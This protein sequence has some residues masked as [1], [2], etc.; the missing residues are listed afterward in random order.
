MA[1][2][3]CGQPAKLWCLCGGVRYCG[4]TCQ[5]QHWDEHKANCASRKKW[6]SALQIVREQENA[7]VV[8]SALLTLDQKKE[9]MRAHAA[10]L[11]AYN[12]NFG[13][14][15]W[16][17][18]QWDLVAVTPEAVTFH[19]KETE[20][21]L[22][23]LQV[24]RVT[25]V[26]PSHID[27]AGLGLLARRDLPEGTRLITEGFW[28]PKLTDPSF[29]CICKTLFRR[30]LAV[31]LELGDIT[32]KTEA[33]TLLYL[34][35]HS[36]NAEEQLMQWH[37]L[38]TETGGPGCQLASLQP[39]DRAVVVLV[40]DLAGRDTPGWSLENIGKLMQVLKTFGF[41][42]PLLVPFELLMSWKLKD[43]HGSVDTETLMPS[44]HGYHLQDPKLM[45]TVLHPQVSRINN[46]VQ[47]DRANVI[48]I[49]LPPFGNRII[50]QVMRPV[51]TGEELLAQYNCDSIR[52]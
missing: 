23:M 36:G 40:W 27:G 26:A 35:L 14:E 6:K 8:E 43:W 44:L 19:C 52:A 5:K 34:V 30:L 46:S 4:R 50:L 15:H 32:I 49:Y 20:R 31:Q 41:A 21:E 33:V 3:G 1:C 25:V 7:V 47:D 2:A 51:K 16:S 18:G 12:T 24:E 42:V 9:A 17:D 38:H 39:L 28:G 37:G 22:E 11:V 45:L 13:E 48:W 29:Q 10:R